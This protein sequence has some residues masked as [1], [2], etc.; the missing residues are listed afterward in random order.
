MQLE[1]LHSIVLTDL[2]ICTGTKKW[3]RQQKVSCEVCFF[4]KRIQDLARGVL[5]QVDSGSPLVCKSPT[6]NKKIVVGIASKAYSPMSFKPA[7]FT[8]I[9]PYLAWIDKNLIDDQV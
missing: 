8:H 1:E 4:G 3:L 2:H 6:S 5:F 7:V 9:S